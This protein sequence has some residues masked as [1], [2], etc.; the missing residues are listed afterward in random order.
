MCA[1]DENEIRWFENKVA[2]SIFGSKREQVTGGYKKCKARNFATCTFIQ[3]VRLLVWLNERGCVHANGL[4]TKFYVTDLRGR[5]SY[6]DLCILYCVYCVYCAYCVYC[7][8]CTY[9]VLCVLCAL[10]A[11]GLNLTDS[12]CG[13]LVQNCQ[14]SEGEFIPVHTIKAYGEWRYTSTQS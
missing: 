8:Y 2:R 13:P 5:N 11:K 12:G 7:V 1:F 3:I 9:C 14:Y 6:E 4:H 10:W